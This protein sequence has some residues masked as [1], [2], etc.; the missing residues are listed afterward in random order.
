MRPTDSSLGPPRWLVVA[1]GACVLAAVTCALLPQ[2]WLLARVPIVPGTNLASR[3]RWTLDEEL[4]MWDR[5]LPWYAIRHPSPLPRLV[6]VTDPEQ[7][8]GHR[9]SREV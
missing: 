5:T 8:A 2:E 4:V 1:V 3:A 6:V 9:L 7:P